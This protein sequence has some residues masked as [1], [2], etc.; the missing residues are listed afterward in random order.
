MQKGQFSIEFIAVLGVLLT[1]MASVTLPLYQDSRADAESITS[2]AQAKEAAE[3]LAN[4]LNGVSSGIGNKQTI[5][6]TLPSDV[7]E[8]RIN[9]NISGPHNRVEVQILGDWEGNKVS[10]ETLLPSTNHKNWDGKPLIDASGLDLNPGD[11]K[12][13]VKYMY[14]DETHENLWIKLEEI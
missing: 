6:Y 9:E 2:M 4:A 11:N 8:I 14:P 12:I 1:I 5:E 3:K 13:L 7:S 10:V